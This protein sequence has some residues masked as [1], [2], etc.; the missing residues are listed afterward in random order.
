M[1]CSEVANPHNPLV[2]KLYA[3]NPGFLHHG[4]KLNL[5]CD[6]QICSG[7]QIRF[8]TITAHFMF[9]I[10]IGLLVYCM[11]PGKHLP[12]LRAFVSGCHHGSFCCD[13]SR[14]W[15]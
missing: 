6:T 1:S 8:A 9:C 10:T 4:F 12:C 5:D 2:Q 7:S 14:R 11:C 3:G 13:Y 15:S